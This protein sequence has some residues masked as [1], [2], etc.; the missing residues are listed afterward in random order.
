VK[1]GKLKALAVTSTKRLDDVPNVP[2]LA[3]AGFGDVLGGSGWF[4]FLAPVGTPAAVVR[5]FNEEMN[6]AIKSPEVIERVQKAYAFAEGGTPEDFTK[7]LAEEGV[8]WTK[9]V[10]DANIKPD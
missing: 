6:K 10:K 8:R 3:E 1:A 5:R 7:F 2:T 9:L 4:G